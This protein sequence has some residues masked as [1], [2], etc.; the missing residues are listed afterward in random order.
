VV[1]DSSLQLPTALFVGSQIGVDLF[2]VISG[3][4]ITGILLRTRGCPAYLRSFY[5][6]RALRILPLATVVIGISALL[7]PV[8]RHLAPC[9]LLFVNNYCSALGYGAMVHIGQMW[10]LAVEEQFYVLFPLV[11]LLTPPRRL[12]LAVAGLIIV[13]CTLHSLNPTLFNRDFADYAY[14][15]AAPMT[16]ERAHV[17][18]FGAWIALVCAGLVPRA[19]LTTVA[20]VLAMA[21]SMLAA[22]GRIGLAEIVAY[23]TMMA[24]VYGTATRRF[25]LSCPPLRYIGVRCYAMYLLHMFVLAGLSQAGLYHWAVSLAV[26]LWVLILVADLTYRFFERPILAK[27]SGRLVAW[28]IVHRARRMVSSWPG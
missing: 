20:V 27:R 14:Y 28:P 9:Y 22:G 12:Y 1:L 23:P 26:S 13:P 24:L 18:G 4:L 5:A 25:V 10:S 15:A 3:F 19:G 7:E 21:A 8:T 11:C 16:H 17:I 2:F 6:R